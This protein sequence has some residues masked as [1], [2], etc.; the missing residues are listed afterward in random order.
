MHRAVARYR[1]LKL[2][3]SHFLE[4]MIIGSPFR[5]SKGPLAASLHMLRKTTP[6]IRVDLPECLPWINEAEV[7][8]P[9]FQVSV[10]RTNYGWQGLESLMSISLR[11]QLGPLPLHRCLI[12]THIQFLPLPSFLILFL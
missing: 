6:Y 9:A 11:V 4:M 8:L 5:R 10:Q 3:Q 1:D 12:R 2:H 7:V